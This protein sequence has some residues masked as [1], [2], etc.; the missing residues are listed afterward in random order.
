MVLGALLDRQEDSE[1][2]VFAVI[3]GEAVGITGVGVA[4][5][6]VGASALDRRTGPAIGGRAGA[7]GGILGT[8]LIGMLRGR[9]TP[10]TRIIGTTI[11][12]RTGRIY[13]MTM[14]PIRRE[15]T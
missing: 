3:A 5:A 4:G 14:T 8:T 2:A 6:E 7:S 11:R 10:T 15:A 1:A 9:H 13:R 12:R